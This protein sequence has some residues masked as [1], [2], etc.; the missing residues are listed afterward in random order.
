MVFDDLGDAAATLGVVFA[1]CLE[2]QDVGLAHG[3]VGA[4][5][6]VFGRRFALIQ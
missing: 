2:F 3:A 1:P 5:G 4:A 6:Q